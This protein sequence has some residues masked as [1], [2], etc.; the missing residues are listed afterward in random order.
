MTVRELITAL[1]AYNPEADVV[2]WCMANGACADDVVAVNIL[3]VASWEGEDKMIADVVHINLDVSALIP[4]WSHYT[5]QGH[6]HMTKQDAVYTVYV[7]AEALND[8]ASLTKLAR[9]Y[10]RNGVAGALAGIASL[11]QEYSFEPPVL[12]SAVRNQTWV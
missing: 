12:E 2:S 6:T 3:G 8:P 4:A 7:L 9:A 10:G 1:Q 11:A 5:T